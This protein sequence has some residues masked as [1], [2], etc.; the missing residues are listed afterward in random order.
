MS[1]LADKETAVAGDPL[2]GQLVDLGDRGL[3]IEDHAVTH[4]ADLVGMHDAGRDQ[5][6]D[7]LDIAH[8]NGVAGVGTTLEAHHDVGAKGKVVDYLG[9]AFISPLG[10]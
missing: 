10:S 3:G 7:E 8:L 2:L 5:M 9:L 4:H 1:A 6:E